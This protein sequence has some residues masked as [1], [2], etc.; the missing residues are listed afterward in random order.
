MRQGGM[1]T[2]EPHSPKKTPLGVRFQPHEIAALEA[3]AKAD[4]RPISALVRRVAL[5][6]LRAHGWLA[7]EMNKVGPKRPKGV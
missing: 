3:A 7:P 4:D 6:W 5:E 1:T 2:P